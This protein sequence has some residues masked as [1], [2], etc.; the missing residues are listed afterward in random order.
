VPRRLSLIA[1]G[2]ALVGCETGTEIA[3]VATATAVRHGDRAVVTATLGCLLAKGMP[4][5]DGNCDADNTTVC[6]HARWYTAAPDAT[7]TPIGESASCEHIAHVRTGTIRLEV[8]H[9][10]DTARVVVVSTDDQPRARDE[11]QRQGVIVTLH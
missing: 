1:L 3:G 7:A 2:A 5:A 6:V 11:A 10:P 9:L 4:R 8:A